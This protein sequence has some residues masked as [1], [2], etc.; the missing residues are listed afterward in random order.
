MRTHDDANTKHL[1]NVDPTTGSGL[2]WCT[3]I[4][5]R[6]LAGISITL[7]PGGTTVN[8]VFRLQTTDYGEDANHPPVASDWV[9]YPASYHNGATPPAN[10]AATMASAIQWQIIDL[11]SKWLR[12][13]FAE[14]SST[15]PLV[16]VA[17]TGRALP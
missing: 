12:I 9:D 5:T 15:A 17:F 2:T 6:G 13:V 4:E 10:V 11:R 8:G 7:K 3:P 14:G 16:S 1:V